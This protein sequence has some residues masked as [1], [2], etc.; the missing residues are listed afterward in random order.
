MVIRI[1]RK[2]LMSVTR[3]PK[4]LSQVKSSFVKETERSRQNQIGDP[5]EK[6]EEQSSSRLTLIAALATM[7]MLW[8]SFPPVGLWFLAWVAPAPLIW[9]CGLK[10]LPGKRPYRSLWFAGLVYWLATFYFIP[11]PH[12]ALW[13]GW[14]T[15]SVYLSLYTVLLVG[16]TRSLVHGC[17]I[18]LWI[19]APVAWTGV[20]WMRCNLLTGMGMVCLSHSQFKLP[21]IIQVADLFGG[22]TLTFVMVLFA[23]SLIGIPVYA[24]CCERKTSWF[25][26]FVA[27]GSIAVVLGYG[28]FRLNEAIAIDEKR[29]LNLA[30]VQS[31]VDTNLYERN[32]ESDEKFEQSCQL[33]WRARGEAAEIDLIVWPESNLPICDVMSINEKTPEWL[34]DYDAAGGLQKGWR[35]ATGFPEIFPEPVA[36]LAGTFGTYIGD[37]AYNST[38]LIDRRGRIVERY[39]KNHRVMFGEYYPILE[40]I[41]G[42][43][44]HFPSCAAGTVPKTFELNDVKLAPSICFET[45][46]PHLIRRHLNELKADENEPDAMINLTNDGWFYGTSCL[47]FHLACNV[48]RAVEMRKTNLVCANTGFS[49]EIDSC[50]RILQRGPRRDVT[51][52]MVEVRG[53]DRSSIYREIGDWI[54]IGMAAICGLGLA[55]GWYGRRRSKATAQKSF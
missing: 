31:S 1:E 48:F 5:E 53:M 2:Q 6:S 15:V 42:F 17:R 26:A 44:K 35:L 40:W 11:I 43:S 51:V 39:F 30:L 45:T 21:I 14:M 13:F 27:V 55:V 24:S 4:R 16:T 10:R 8:L 18:P 22:Y 38:V 9:L 33:T 29:S 23:T 28:Q 47:D 34:R 7:T 41:P 19:A 3:E 52:L 50:G 32:A 49:G 46:V 25:Q 20:E 54:P 36:L 37:E 12:W